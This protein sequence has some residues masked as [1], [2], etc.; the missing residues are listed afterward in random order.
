MNYISARARKKFPAILS[1]R[2]TS[3]LVKELFGLLDERLLLKHE[4][5]VSFFIL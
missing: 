4:F 3:N 5:S 2:I 1:D